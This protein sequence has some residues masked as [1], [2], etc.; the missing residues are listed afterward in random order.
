[1]TLRTKQAAMPLPDIQNFD[2]ASVS[3]KF[4]ESMYFPI[5]KI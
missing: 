1:M 5:T 3:Q 2:P 4:Q